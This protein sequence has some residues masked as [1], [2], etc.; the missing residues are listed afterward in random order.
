MVPPNN[1]EPPKYPWRRGYNSKMN[2]LVDGHNLI[3]KTGGQ[4]SDLDDESS[5]LNLL[6]VFGRVRRPKNLEVFFDG[7]PPGNSGRRKIGWVVVHNVLKGRT[8][9]ESIIARL[10]ILGKDAHN[11]IVVSSDRR[12]Q[13][14]SRLRKAQVVSSETFAAELESALQQARVQ[15]RTDPGAMDPSELDDWMKLFSEKK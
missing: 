9:D 14:E 7:A 1:K 4:L 11:W 5:L 8:A 3:P 6:Q 10:N 2:Y 15:T 12:V 13:T